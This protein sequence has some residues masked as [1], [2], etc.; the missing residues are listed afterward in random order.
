[1]RT[2]AAFIL[3]LLALAAPPEAD[4]RYFSFARD[5]QINE[6]GRQNFLV[7][8][9]D[10]FQHGRTDLADLR[11][12]DGD[13]Q[14]PYKLSEAR[15]GSSSEERE[16]RIL[17]L[18]AAGDHTEFDLDMQGVPEYDNIRLR[19]DAKNFVVKA[20]VEGS[21]TLHG[22]AVAPWPTPSTLY[23]FSAE[24]L[25]SNFT[26]KLP[27]WS[28]RY[29]HVKLGPG[30]RPQQVQGATVSNLQEKRA[31]YLPV[32]SCRLLEPGPHQT[33]WQCDLPEGVP[34]DR[35][36]F[37]VVSQNVNFRR[38]VS[39]Q[40]DKGIQI[41]GGELSRI[42]T[43]RGGT[44]V[45][46]ENLALR[47]G[48]ACCKR[49]TIVVDNGD[50]LPLGIVAVQPQSL[51]RRLY[52][53]PGGR[54]ALRLYFGDPKLEAPVYD[55]AKLF[56]EDMDAAQASLGPTMPNSAYTPRADDRPWSERH[57]SVLWIAMLLAVVVLA[58]LA[59]RGLAAQ[60]G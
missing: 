33:R 36:V 14:V 40:D 31:F 28:F 6:A 51:Q 32:G 12:Y 29:V 11:L 55:Y 26:I 41:A 9:A 4:R 47:V 15:A 48:G 27:T 23:D 1:M 34:L 24:R 54:S 8:D 57:P 42:R 58:V 18:A 56:H 59:I 2:T 13:R 39:V 21:D 5:V 35:I 7:L 17:D 3:A 25:G 38:P 60:R 43:R 46:A 53:E 20:S 19:L 49:I 22:G 45:V 10:V 16:V 52:F 50:D 44:D 30:I 37:D